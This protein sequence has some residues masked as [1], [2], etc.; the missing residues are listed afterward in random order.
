MKSMDERLTAQVDDVR[1]SLRHHTAVQLNSLRKWL[2]DPIEP[3][4][5]LALVEDRWMYT[6]AEGFPSRVKDFWRLVSDPTTLSKL[7]EHYSVRDWERWRRATL[8]DI[9][10][11]CYTD[12]KIAVTEHPYK[13]LKALAMMWGLQYSDL[14]RPRTY[15]Q[16]QGLGK[17]KAETDN[18]SRRV[19]ARED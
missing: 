8:K 18:G 19:R 9:N 6:V 14:E 13:C 3:I 5:A 10:V 1:A 7:A 15:L 11:T 12:L 17:R 16:R 2:G 4:L